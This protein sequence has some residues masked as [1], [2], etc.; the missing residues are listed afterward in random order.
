MVL[1]QRFSYKWIAT[2]TTALATWVFKDYLA[3]EHDREMA[4]TGHRHVRG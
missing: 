3:T 1:L 4:A 2:G